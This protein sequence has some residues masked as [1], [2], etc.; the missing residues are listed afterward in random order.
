[1][2]LFHEINISKYQPLH[3][4]LTL[5]FLIAVVTLE[6]DDYVQHVNHNKKEIITKSRLKFSYEKLCLCHGARPKLIAPI[7]KSNVSDYVLGIRDT[8]SV[9]AFQEKLKTSSRICIVGNGGIATEM[10][11]ELQ[12]VDVIWAI[13][14]DSI[15]ATFVDAGAAEFFISDFHDK[16]AKGKEHNIPTKRMKYTVSRENCDKRCT[17]GGALGPDWH[18]KIHR[19]GFT[20]DGLKRVH[21]EYNCDIKR[22]LS[23]EELKEEDLNSTIDTFQRIITYDQMSENTNW[24]IYIELNNGRIFGCDF[25][26]SATGV[27]P[28]GDRIKLIDNDK[29]NSFQLATDGAIKVNEE[30]ET[31]IKDIYA[32]GDV[33]H[34][35]WDSS[36]HWFQMRLWTQ[37]RQMGMFAAQCM[38]TSLQSN[39]N[40]KKDL[41]FCFEMFTHATKFFGYKVILLGLFNGQKNL[42]YE[43]LLRMTKGK[44]Y[45]KC[46]MSKDGRMQ[47]AILIGET[48]LEETFENLI[49]NQMD[50]TIYGVDLLDPNIDIEDYFD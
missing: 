32:A 47:G 27:I 22:L 2:F 10:V 5:L 9:S 7:V 44:E 14:D 38:Y 46:V 11:Y 36:K 30:M 24:N 49:L 37:A 35:N 8:E 28:N 3:K 41:D 43:V 45:I 18:G 16:N 33:C 17:D 21:V 40:E 29:E 42:D 23:R 50:L 1:M 39:G 34:V 19:K 15:A 12:A 31:S 4:T 6:P 20:E 26:V 48:D 13:K 25:I